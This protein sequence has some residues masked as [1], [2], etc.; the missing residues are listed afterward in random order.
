METISLAVGAAVAY[1]A[2]NSGIIGKKVVKRA[3]KRVVK[4]VRRRVVS[5]YSKAR[6]KKKVS[7][8][9][10]KR[11]IKPIKRAKRRVLRGRSV[12]RR[13]MGSSNPFGG[14]FGFA[15]SVAR[16]M[17]FGGYPQMMY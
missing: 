15:P 11:G 2:L 16:P 8:V 17:S 1:V 9:R 4:S 5:A 6:P 12:Q 13:F 10:V 14:S 3:R 7:P